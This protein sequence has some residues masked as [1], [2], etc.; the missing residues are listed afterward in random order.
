MPHSLTYG[1]SLQIIRRVGVAMLSCILLT[2]PVGDWLKSSSLVLQQCRCNS[3]S[4]SVCS[5]D[6]RRVRADP[7]EG[8]TPLELIKYAMQKLLKHVVKWS[9]VWGNLHHRRMHWSAFA[10][11]CAYVPVCVGVCVCVCAN[12]YVCEYV[13]AR[14]DFGKFP[15]SFIPVKHTTLTMII[16]TNSQKLD[17]L[18]IL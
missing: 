1:Q 11:K 14:V 7:R 16:F 8:G 3:R 12:T 2:R 13:C 10:W 5:Y 15:V 18:R 9:N 4:Q 17:E 6:E